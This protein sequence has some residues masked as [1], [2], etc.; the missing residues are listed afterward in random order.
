[1]TRQQS[2]VQARTINGERVIA[3]QIQTKV[4]LGHNTQHVLWLFFFRSYCCCF[5]FNGPWFWP[6]FLHVLLFY[7][8]FSR[9][10]VAM[11]NITRAYI[12]FIHFQ[13]HS[14]C[15]FALHMCVWES[16]YT[17]M[18]FVHFFVYFSILGI[19]YDAGNR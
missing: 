15:I 13:F 12:H 14:F 11:L 19:C 2:V 7:H 6:L 17:L 10:D 18:P 3:K 4:L 16:T 5:L 8:S 1:M 9:L